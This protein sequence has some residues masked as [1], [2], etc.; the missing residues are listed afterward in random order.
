MERRDQPA[1]QEGQVRHHDRWKR[2]PLGGAQ[3][4]LLSTCE[5]R[6]GLPNGESMQMGGLAQSLKAMNG[7]EGRC[8]LGDDPGL[9]YLGFECQDGLLP[10][11][12]WENPGDSCFSWTLGSSLRFFFLSFVFPYLKDLSVSPS[13][14]R[15]T[16][17]FGGMEARSWWSLG[18]STKSFQKMTTP[19]PGLVVIV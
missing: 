10:I 9:H 16:V 13:P 3:K 12:E 4:V 7:V 2:R 19:I 14:G 15:A 18:R 1:V 11:R 8:V 6:E 5:G 17:A